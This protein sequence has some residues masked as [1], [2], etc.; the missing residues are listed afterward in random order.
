[1]FWIILILLILLSIYL[2]VQNRL[3]RLNPYTVT[4][5]N[6]PDALKGKKIVHLTDLHIKPNMN[7]GYLKTI[8]GKV[9]DQEPDLIVLTGDIVHANVKDI[10]ET[11]LE[12]FCEELSSIA[13]TYAVTGNHDIGN[14]DFSEVGSILN[15]CGITLLIDDAQIVNFD[16]EDEE[17][18][19]VIMGFA[20][21]GDMQNVPKP[22]LKNI[23]L[24]EEMKDKTKILLAH[25]PEFFE[26]YVEDYDKAPDLTFAGHTHGGQV[27][28]PYFGGVYAPGQDFFPKYDSGLFIS[29]TDETKRMFV[30]KGL[31]NSSFPLRINNRVEILTVIL[32]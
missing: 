12:E 6:L 28:F 18:S 27:I 13:K 7:T 19:L 20:Q 21:R 2:Y 16:E 29:E 26:E 17:Q 10:S 5:P 11:Y 31:G 30:S 15:D 8:I 1:M 9:Q 23:E 24:S 3:I 25:Q 22:Y 32:N 14:P 4:V